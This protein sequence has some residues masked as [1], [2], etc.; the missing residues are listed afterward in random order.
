MNNIVGDHK[1]GDYLFESASDMIRLE[2]VN[3]SAEEIDE[4]IEAL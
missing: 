2:L 4:F 1:L 3:L